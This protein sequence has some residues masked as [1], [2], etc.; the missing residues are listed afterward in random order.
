MTFLIILIFFSKTPLS[1]SS[2]K[3][4]MSL[5]KPSREPDLISY[6]TSELDSIEIYVVSEITGNP[7]RGSETLRGHFLKS[8]RHVGSDC[9]FSAPGLLVFNT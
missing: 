7:P 4:T 8:R 3:Q 5:I 1:I 9:S 2:A 6:Q